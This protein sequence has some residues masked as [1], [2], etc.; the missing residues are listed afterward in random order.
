MT[1]T[2]LRSFP[3]ISHETIAIAAKARGAILAGL[4]SRCNALH[5]VAFGA[6]PPGES[7]RIFPGH[8]HTGSEAI[9]RGC[10]LSIDF[11]ENLSMFARSIGSGELNQWLTVDLGGVE[12]RPGLVAY[13][14]PGVSSDVTAEGG[15]AASIVAD[16]LLNCTGSVNLD[17]RFYN[18]RRDAYSS[19]GS[20]GSSGLQA[21]SISDVPV[22]SG[23]D[24]LELQIRSSS[25]MTFRLVALT[26][27]ETRSRSQP[28][29]TGTVFSSL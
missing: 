22:D 18:R 8:R 21:P 25:V 11:G 4:I 14:T 5:E 17:M 24:E 23:I 26:L 13:T 15:S 1:E 20:V 12:R 7:S 10:L 28:Q 27:N 16:I 2:F 3:P 29:T 19:I 6:A 9:P